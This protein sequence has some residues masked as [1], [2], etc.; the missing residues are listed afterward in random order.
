MIL[1]QLMDSG[2]DLRSLAQELD[3]PV[4]AGL[5]HQ[6]DVS[7]IPAAMVNDY[8]KPSRTV[9]ATGIVV[10]RG[11][12]SGN[13]HLLL[14][15]GNVLFH[16][17]SGVRDQP[18]TGLHVCP[19]GTVAYLDHPEHGNSAIAPGCYV[20]RRRREMAGEMRLVTD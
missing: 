3:I 15:A 19:E 2:M 4:L 7:V 1:S 18:H 13:T 17:P 6:G 9:L 8:V 11:E 20:L 16:P 10:V 14:A 5:Q 12:P